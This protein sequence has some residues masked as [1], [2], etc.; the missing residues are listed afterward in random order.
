MELF[1]L[2]ERKRNTQKITDY[3]ESLLTPVKVKEKERKANDKKIL[4]GFILVL[5]HWL[6]TGIPLVYLIIGK[7]NMYF[8]LLEMGWG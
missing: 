4:N 2:E 6:L 8:Y 3:C 1:S 7:V 5:F